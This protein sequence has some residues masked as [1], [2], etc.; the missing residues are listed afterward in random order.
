M[1]VVAG[2]ISVLCLGSV[3]S[4]DDG[5]VGVVS[6]ELCCLVAEV[7]RKQPVFPFKRESYV[8]V[9][10]RGPASIHVST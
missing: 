5:I 6:C 3:G 1:Y 7:V 8:C 9:Y 2:D 10:S 4:D